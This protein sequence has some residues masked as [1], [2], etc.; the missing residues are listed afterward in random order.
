MFEVITNI[1]KIPHLRKRLLT[2]TLSIDGYRADG[3][4]L[5]KKDGKTYFVSRHLDR[6]HVAELQKMHLMPDDCEPVFYK[7]YFGFVPILPPAQKDIFAAFNYIGQGEKS[8]LVHQDMPISVY[9]MLGREFHLVLDEDA[10]VPI[11]YCYTLSRDFVE[12]RFAESADVAVSF[13][14]KL[15]EKSEDRAEL[16]RYL[17]NRSDTRFELLDELMEKEGVDWMLFTSPLGIQEVTGFGMDH[18]KEDQFAALYQAKSDR[19]YFLSAEYLWGFG[20]ES[21]VHDAA[22]F[23]KEK[24]GAGIVG[25]EE[26]HFSYGWLTYFGFKNGQWKKEQNLARNLR[27]YRGAYNLPYYIMTSKI[28]SYAMRKATAWAKQQVQERKQI[29]ELDANAKYD[30]YVHEFCL[31]KQ[32][33][34]ILDRYWTNA[35]AS[36]RCITPSYAFD[37]PITEQSKAF[38]FDAGLLVKDHNGILLAA[39]DIA[40][41]FATDEVGTRMYDVLKEVVLK[42]IADG[43]RAGQTGEEIYHMTAREMETY[44]EELAPMGLMPKEYVGDVFA[45]DVG[46][47]LTLHEPG[48]LWFE[49]GSSVQTREGMMCAHE[50]Q[51]TALG[52]SVG[53]EDNFFIAKDR[54][55]NLSIDEADE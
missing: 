34:L 25:V 21:V 53:Y 14:K 16:E 10:Y 6:A 8:V 39:S 3:P 46:H 22:A 2:A 27:L 38:K 29:T 50:I 43:V 55:I 40:R 11:R 5:V 23:V 1:N 42:M 32:M 28:S 24:I 26:L 37:H 44:R 49:K 20:D 4:L 7:P 18:Y 13:A 33:P 36:D 35:H 15:I 9:E 30:E 54:C 47:G 51:W 41:S 12:K 48:T 17:D 31:K 19:V 45:R 52:Y